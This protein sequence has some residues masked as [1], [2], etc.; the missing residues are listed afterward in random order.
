M[1]VSEVE[2]GKDRLTMW[3]EWQTDSSQ[4]PCSSGRSRPSPDHSNP[5]DH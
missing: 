3:L 2:E 4:L 1:K 5:M